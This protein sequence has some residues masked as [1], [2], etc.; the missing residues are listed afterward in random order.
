MHIV[1]DLLKYLIHPNSMIRSS[2]KVIGFSF[3]PGPPG[4]SASASYSVLI[5]GQRD[6]GDDFFDVFLTK[7]FYLYAAGRMMDRS[8]SVVLL[9]RI[10]RNEIYS[11]KRK[12]TEQGIKAL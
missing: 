10:L 8:E 5:V 3:L 11:C 9:Y 4:F 1:V 12:L 6:P 7:S 2:A